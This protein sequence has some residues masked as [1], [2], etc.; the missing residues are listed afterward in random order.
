MGFGV[1][2]E[3]I[4]ERGEEEEREYMEPHLLSSSSSSSSDLTTSFL[5]NTKG[6]TKRFQKEFERWIQIVKYL[7]LKKSLCPETLV[8]SLLALSETPSQR[9]KKEK[10]KKE[11]EEREWEENGWGEEKEEKAGR[12]TREDITPFSNFVCGEEFSPF[13]FGSCFSSSSSSSSRLFFQQEKEKQNKKSPRSKWLK[14]V[15]LSVFLILHKLDI[16]P[17]SLL[18]QTSSP[19]LLLSFSRDL[20]SSFFSLSLHLRPQSERNCLSFLFSEFSGM[21]SSSIFETLVPSP[22]LRF[23]LFSLLSLLLNSSTFHFEEWVEEMGEREEEKKDLFSAVESLYSSLSVPFSFS[24]SSYHHENETETPETETS[25]TRFSLNFSPTPPS[26]STFSSSSSTPTATLLGPHTSSTPPEKRVSCNANFFLF[27][28]VS[29]VCP[30]HLPLQE[31]S[32]CS[33]CLSPS[34]PSSLDPSLFRSLQSNPTPC[35]YI[36][37]IAITATLS[38]SSSSSDPSFL[39]PPFSLSPLLPSPSLHL[40]HFLFILLSKKRKYSQLCDYPTAIGD[41]PAMNES[42]PRADILPFLVDSI[43]PL[44]FLQLII[45]QMIQTVCCEGVVVDIFGFLCISCEVDWF[46]VGG[47]L[48]YIWGNCQDG[49]SSIEKAM[50]QFI[51]EVISLRVPS[52]CVA[53]FLSLTRILG[54]AVH[55]RGEGKEREKEGERGEERERKK[56]KEKE[57]VLFARYEDWFY[58]LCVKPSPAFLESLSHCLIDSLRIDSDEYLLAHIKVF[59]LFFFVC[60]CCLFLLFVLFN[61]FSGFGFGFLKKLSKKMVFFTGSGK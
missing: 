13:S 57:K 42:T 52:F 25:E 22:S 60:F 5:S 24:S 4:Q 19:S 48:L 21:S 35:L 6:F 37:S 20:Y 16:I 9:K 1:V 10:E 32:P 27:L 14:R 46:Y 23:Y 38:L 7:L 29:Q 49:P 3:Q 58:R 51:S 40:R 36:S 17:F 39:L 44:Y 15:P 12:E 59:F 43:P 26:N 61:F 28:L 53:N 11:G 55:I 34:S 18:L 33:L 45:Q 30:F 31:W 41:S 50:K 2:V 54:G 56:E 47:I 8:C